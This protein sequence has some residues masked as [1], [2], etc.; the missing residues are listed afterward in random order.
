[1][2]HEAGNGGAAGI[3]VA[4]VARLA[5]LDLTEAEI[6]TFQPQ[7]DQI[8]EYVRKIGALNVEGIEPTS[9]AH[10]VVNVFRRDEPRAGLDRERVLSNAPAVVQDQFMVPK[11]VE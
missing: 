8:L 5:R 2:I 11:I 3:D 4:Y 6:R 9:H 7:L 1:M 10:P